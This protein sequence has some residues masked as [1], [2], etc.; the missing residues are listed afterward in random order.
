VAKPVRLVPKPI[1]LTAKR[2]ALA[3]QQKAFVKALQHTGILH[4]GY[5][6]CTQGLE[7]SHSGRIAVQWIVSQTPE[8]TQPQRSICD[9]ARKMRCVHS[10]TYTV[11]KLI[12]WSKRPSG[13]VRRRLSDKSLKYKRTNALSVP[14]SDEI[15][16]KASNVQLSEA[17]K[18]GKR[19]RGEVRKRVVKQ[20]EPF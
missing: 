12:A 10:A 19:I 3:A 1:G 16:R 20:A 7:L 14:P 5:V 17:S 6:S 18:R 15:D 8:H 13:R 11:V 9:K 4:D 2:W